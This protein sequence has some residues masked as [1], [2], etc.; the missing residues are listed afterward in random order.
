MCGAAL[1][2]GVI[3]LPAATKAAGP[4]LFIKPTKAAAF[5]VM[6]RYSKYVEA[7]LLPSTVYLNAMAEG[8]RRAARAMAKNRSL[9]SIDPEI[10]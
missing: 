3:G 5:T 2:A 7:E 4:V 8:L 1:G 10:I 6:R 9:E